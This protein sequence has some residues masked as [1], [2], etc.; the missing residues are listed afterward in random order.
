[1]FPQAK[2]TDFKLTL[3]SKSENVPSFA[4]SRG[5]IHH[6]PEALPPPPLNRRPESFNNTAVARSSASE[7]RYTS[8]SRN[9]DSMR[10]NLS[11][12]PQEKPWLHNKLKRQPS[13]T[14]LGD[15]KDSSAYA[16]LPAALEPEPI[17]SYDTTLVATTSNR[18]ISTNVQSRSSSVNIPQTAQPIIISPEVCRSVNVKSRI[19]TTD[20][21]S[22]LE[23][24]GTTDNDNT[25]RNS[26]L[27]ENNDVNM[28]QQNGN[29]AQNRVFESL[30]LT[31]ANVSKQSQD[32]ILQNTPEN[33]LSVTA[34][35]PLTNCQTN[36]D[37]SLP[38]SRQESVVQNDSSVDA[39]TPLPTIED[40]TTDNIQVQHN[41][42][43][44]N[45][46]DNSSVKK[47]MSD[48]DLI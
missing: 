22:S 14:S 2:S 48:I 47:Q 27:N 19:D 30:P 1:M 12:S 9:V 43:K 45:L 6:Y 24:N 10:V 35:S 44:P 40:E 38:V 17:K 16:K 33:T 5:T 8:N 15:N 46:E 31:K 21:L 37:V 25:G 11:N 23:T 36:D 41:E 39:S 4:S 42:Y 32:L 3:P 26:T 34:Q 20:A 28:F 18:T 13:T 7:N 29:E